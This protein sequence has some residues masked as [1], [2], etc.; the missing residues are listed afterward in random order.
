MNTL[1][2]KN[3]LSPIVEVISELIVLNE[4]VT[5]NNVDFPDITNFASAVSKQ[6]EHVIKIG[7]TYMENF[8]N[9]ELLQKNLP[10]GCNEGK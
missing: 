9:D 6:V 5:E 4:E 3:I 8:K 10:I 2:K 1:T 7:Y